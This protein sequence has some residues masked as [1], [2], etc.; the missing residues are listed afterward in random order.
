MIKKTP[1]TIQKMLEL[2]T[3]FRKVSEYKN[4]NA[5]ANF[6]STH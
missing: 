1:K 5:K 6:V 4:Q 3:E 2:K